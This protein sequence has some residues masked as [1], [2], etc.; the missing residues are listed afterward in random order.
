MNDLPVVL[1]IL[2]GTLATMSIIAALI[3]PKGSSIHRKAG[4]WACVSLGS[5]L[6]LA[7]VISIVNLQYF[8]LLIAC[9]TAY[10]LYTGW[11]IA[12]ATDS[13]I[14]LAD[15]I[16]FALTACIGLTMALIGTLRIFK[17]DNAGYILITFGA[18]ALILA[19]SDLLRRGE[20][21]MAEDRIA[22]H[23]TRMCGSSIATA[24]AIVVVN[25][26][27]QP[28]Y[29]GW[30]APTVIAT[31]LIAFY[32]YKVKQVRGATAKSGE[33]KHI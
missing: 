11:R 25:I 16:V 5:S 30:L 1:H 17:E 31:P 8:L 26:Q 18:I 6:F 12:I 3:T 19:T 33:K 7:I 23:L 29:V 27:T 14:T 15:K 13:V 21:P 22:L 20:W 4:R 32:S 10:L 24:T 28:V 9:F 2:T